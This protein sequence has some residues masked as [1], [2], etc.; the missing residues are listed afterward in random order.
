MLRLT[1]TN[2]DEEPEVSR[3]EG[4]V[5]IYHQNNWLPICY[6]G[7][8]REETEVACKQL[9]FR[10]GSATGVKDESLI[11][12]NWMVNVTCKGNENRLDACVFETFK[13]NGCPELK[14]V[15]LI[16]S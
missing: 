4:Q 10:E 9:G 12:S 5:E 14:Y 11:D 15:S 1:Q 16:C 3:H 8:G 7:W 6:K 13:Q 2:E